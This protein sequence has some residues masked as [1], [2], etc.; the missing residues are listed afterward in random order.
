MQQQNEEARFWDSLNHWR[1]GWRPMGNHRMQQPVPLAPVA[2]VFED[3]RAGLNALVAAHATQVKR[4]TH[5][6]KHWADVV[7][8]NGSVLA[9][10][11]L[12][13]ARD[14]DWPPV[15]LM[16]NALDIYVPL[17]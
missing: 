2:I 4:M 12:Q 14:L 11:A 13:V 1:Q 10:Y 6:A 17:T 3:F 16:M 15:E 8:H 9:W 7:P 5:D